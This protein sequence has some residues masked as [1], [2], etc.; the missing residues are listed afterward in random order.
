VPGRSGR[1]GR[2][3]SGHPDRSSRRSWGWYALREPWAVELVRAADIQADDLA[4][5]LG[6]GHGAITAPL[7]AT[8]AHVVAVELHAG[9]AEVLRSRLAAAIT[10]RQLSVVEA[11]LLAIF[12]PRRPF[13]V[14][15]NP[16]FALAGPLLRRLT[17]R[18]SALATA[19]IVVPRVVATRLLAEQVTGRGRPRFEAA[20][21]TRLPPTAF[22]PAPGIECVA[23]TLRR[24]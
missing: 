23:L 6:A 14:V 10:R 13:H 20:I 17:A 18:D 1:A 12:L 2:P 9:R 3:A 15:A 21:G 5:D 8:G 24:I 7:L 22:R 4:F 16:P 19:R 11:D